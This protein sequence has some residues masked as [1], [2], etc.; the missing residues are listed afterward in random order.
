[1]E[2]Q[3]AQPIDM[4]HGAT[5]PHQPHIHHVKWVTTGLV[6]QDVFPLNPDFGWKH[7]R[8][9]K[10]VIYDGLVV[11]VGPYS[12]V[13]N[14]AMDVDNSYIHSRGNVREPIDRYYGVL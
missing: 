3:P 10:E 4:F 8:D 11:H 14:C 13:F 5:M 2:L 7:L 12:N 1:M 9:L 6:G